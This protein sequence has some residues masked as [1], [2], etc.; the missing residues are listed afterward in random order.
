MTT[1]RSRVSRSLTYD[2][3]A[4]KQRQA[5]INA[6]PALFRIAT[7]LEIRRMRPDILKDMKL[8]PRHSTAERFVWS[9]N[10]AA[11]LRAIRYY[12]AVLVP[13]DSKGGIYQRSGETEKNTK[14]IGNAG[15]TGGDITIE[16]PLRAGKFALNFMSR[17][18]PSHRR[19]GHPR[20]DEVIAK[21]SPISS[22]RLGIQ[23]QNVADP[24]RA[25]RGNR[26]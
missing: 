7:D 5:A 3:N 10:K 11:N 16:A 18:I 17:Q 23:W 4:L 15:K 24:V 26:V 14:V 12:F 1:S 25:V 13:K 20:V 8:K 21:W 22:Q 9:H 2:E 19:S 6:S